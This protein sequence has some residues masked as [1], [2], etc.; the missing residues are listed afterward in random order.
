AWVMRSTS[1]WPDLSSASLRVSDT[2]KTAM[3]TARNG[4]VSSILGMA[5]IIRDGRAVL[6]D[7]GRPVT[8][9][10]RVEC[11]RRLV[12][13]QPVDPIIRQ[14]PHRI[15]ARLGPGHALEEEQGIVAQSGLGRRPPRRRGGAVIVGDG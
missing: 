12:E 2:V 4:R 5:T 8:R 1:V 11:G 13:A 14:H 7:I 6:R 3:L 10:K 15:D 9:G